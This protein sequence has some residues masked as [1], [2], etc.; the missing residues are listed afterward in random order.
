[1]AEL[2]I[3]DDEKHMRELIRIRLDGL[4]HTIRTAEDAQAALTALAERPADVVFCDVQMPG[5]DGIWLTNQIRNRYPYSA[6]VLA[7]AVG[8]IAP[9]V[10]MQ[11]GVMAYLV[12]PFSAHALTDAL[13]AALRWCDDARA[14]GAHPD[15]AGPALSDWL[16]SIKDL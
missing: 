3:V 1:M 12:K 15:D 7:T 5:E 16:D 6:V 2:L 8:S 4:G 9:R 14:A 10:S 11:K 13:S